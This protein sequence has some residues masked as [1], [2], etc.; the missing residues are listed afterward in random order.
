[1]ALNTRVTAYKKPNTSTAPSASLHT[2][3]VV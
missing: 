2:R 1:L 3:L